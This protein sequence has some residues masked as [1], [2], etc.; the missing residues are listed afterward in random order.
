NAW[1]NIRNNSFVLPA[2]FP[3]T[4]TRTGYLAPISSVLPSYQGLPVASFFSD[5]VVQSSRAPTTMFQPGFRTPRVQSYF[6]GIQ[7]PLGASWT[8]ETNYLGSRGRG[9]LTTDN[10]NRTG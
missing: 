9:L 10:Q 8:V 7:Q 1:Q 4:S 2:A 5:P 6:F 3:I